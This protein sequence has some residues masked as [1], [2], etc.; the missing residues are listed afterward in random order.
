MELAMNLSK[1]LIVR[2]AGICVG[3]AVLAIV[4]HVAGI[5]SD[6]EG[7]ILILYV[8]VMANYFGYYLTKHAD[9]I[10]SESNETDQR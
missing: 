4:L 10:L 7:S 5:A 8:L 2:S 9:E 1:G 6:V 3:I